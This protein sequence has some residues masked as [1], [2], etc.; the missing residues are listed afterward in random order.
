MKNYSS[1]DYEDFIKKVQK[2]LGD[3][4]SVALETYDLNHI[5]DRIKSLQEELQDFKIIFENSVSSLHLTDGEGKILKVNP[6]FEKTTGVSRKEVEGKTVKNLEEANLYSP[7]IVRLVLQEKRPLTM[8]QGRGAIQFI[9]TSTPVFDK[10]GNIF[11]VV[12]NARLVDE[13]IMLNEYF[14]K[15]SENNRAP[16]DI[17]VHFIC[18]SKEMKKLIKTLSHVAKAD[19]GILITGESGAGKSLLARYVHDESPRASERFIEI[20][21]AAIPEGLMESELFGYEAGAFTGAKKG[22]K[23]GLIELANK[24][25]LFLDEIGDMPLSLQAKL[26]QVIHKKEFTRVGGEKPINVDIRII[27]ATNKDLEKMVEA[28]AFRNDLYFRLNVIPIHLPSL[29]ERKEDV[30]PLAEYF[31]KKYSDKYQKRIVFSQKVIERLLRYDWP[32]NI[33]EL[34]NLIERLIVT[35]ENGLIMLEHLPSSIIF[36]T[37]NNTEGIV[38]NKLVTLQEAMDQVERQLIINAYKVYNSSYKVAK[39]LGISQAAAFRKIKKYI[40][41]NT[42]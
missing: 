40:K 10:D 17:G 3:E 25:T 26:L 38:I 14:K 16:R 34:E 28:G 6:V 8:L 39:V 23:P 18:E 33:R 22:G 19:S 1:A 41:E 21:C 42:K 37:E 29:R 24:G 27:S 4:N 30:W 7:S 5:L 2:T 32:G 12:S 11:R 35:D 31:I 20:N 36:R 15:L 9:T 13:L